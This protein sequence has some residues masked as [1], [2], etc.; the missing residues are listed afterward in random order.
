MSNN[1]VK[2]GT[3]DTAQGAVVFGDLVEGA[4]FQFDDSTDDDIVMIKSSKGR[5]YFGVDLRD[6]QSLSLG[7][8]DKVK[9]VQEGR[10]I[11]LIVDNQFD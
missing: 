4:I 11:T 6:G 3:L 1:V 9:L 10:E 7:M 8:N 2:L 5:S